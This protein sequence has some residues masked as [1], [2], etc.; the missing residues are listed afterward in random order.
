MS[1]RAFTYCILLVAG[2]ACNRQ[3]P[4]PPGKTSPSTANIAA[5]LARE[6]TESQ[7]IALVQA[8]PEFKALSSQDMAEGT[9]KRKK[10]PSA[11]VVAAPKLQSTSE[12]ES[13][14]WEIAVAD[15]ASFGA[16]GGLT[17]SEPADLDVRVDAYTGA[18]SVLNADG[19][20][21]R[22][23]AAWAAAQR[24]W[25]RSSDLVMSIPE[26]DSEAASVHNSP[27]GRNNA[28]VL[29]LYWADEPRVGCHPGDSDCRYTFTAI[30]I[31]SGCAGGRWVDFEVDLAKQTL[32]V[33]D[34]DF[35]SLV[36]YGKWR[37][38]VRT[39]AG[40]R[41]IEEYRPLVDS[42]QVFP[43]Y[44]LGDGPLGYG[45][46]I[47]KGR[48]RVSPSL[49]TALERGGYVLVRTE[50][51]AGNFI[52]YVVQ[53]LVP[54]VAQTRDLRA[55]GADIVR[56]NGGRACE[57]ALENTN[58]RFQFDGFALKRES[59]GVYVFIDGDFHPWLKPE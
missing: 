49:R 48:D 8:L 13:G 6:L 4:T 51:Y 9:K 57:V 44:R 56:A 47:Q 23:Y 53:P 19:K 2:F 41:G 35:P 52:V 3:A 22:E 20:T 28:A 14:Y 42:R 12:N 15:Q 25:Y 29:S 43:E 27:A 37:H 18:I 17:T 16:D 5:P 40:N 31:C 39:L 24:G 10:I 32:F 55:W 38:H 36:A 7:A 59:G 21:F 54:G 45:M 34:N 50:R 46:P 26:W 30:S 58:E 33:N 11:H 1:P